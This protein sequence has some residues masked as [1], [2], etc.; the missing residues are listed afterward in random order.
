MKTLVLPLLLILGL[1][2][3]LAG[4]PRVRDAELDKLTLDEL[5][6]IE[7]QTATRRPEVPTRSPVAVTVLTRDDIR[8]SGAQTLVELL[9]LVPGVHVAQIDGNKWAVGI[10]GFADRLSRG[11]LVMIDGRTVYTP[12][13]AGTY[14]EM[15]HTLLEDID[16]IEVIRGPGGTLWGA[17]AVNGIINVI[18][19]SAADTQGGLLTGGGGNVQHGMASGRYGGRISRTAAYRLY[20]TWFNR[21]P[22]AATDGSSIDGWSMAQGGFRADWT[23]ARTRVLT[24]QGDVYRGDAGQRLVATTY[25]PPFS[26]RLDDDVALTGANL[27]VRWAAGARTGSN[28]VVQTY[29]DRTHRTEALFTEDRH[30]F[31]VDLQHGLAPVGRHRL[32]WGAGY[33]L[34]ADAT[35]AVPIRQ[36]EPAD[37]TT[38]LVSAFAQDQI[39][40]RQN[41]LDLVLGSRFEHNAYSGFEWQPSARLVWTPAPLHT[42]VLSATRAVRTPS[43][44]E[45]DYTTGS[46]L[47]AQVP[48]CLRLEP[49]RDF[50]SE[51]LRG[52][53]ASYRVRLAPQMYATVAGFFNHLTDVLS[54]RTAPP[55]AETAVQP[56]RLILP[57]TFGN[58]L[59]GNSHGMEATLDLRPTPWWSWTAAYSGLRVQL[60]RD[61]GGQDVSQEERGE[62]GSPNHQVQIRSSIDLPGAV[63]IDWAFRYVSQ[64]PVFDVPGYATSDLRAGWHLTRQVSLEVVGR[65]LHRPRHLEFPGGATGNVLVRRGV[66]ARVVTRW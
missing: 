48:F 4:Q 15:Q 13:F 9:R 24:V 50:T 52:Y 55:F 29:V 3:V 16:R 1:P 41:A 11:M 8:R 5:L 31:D 19:K 53:E 18:T 23:P 65:N 54:T 39:T 63:E 34:S 17:N 32:L 37:R 40:L 35:D 42:A 21:G 2:P 36:F 47:N 60:T 26:Q 61:A 44:V 56:P 6:E 57:V 46:V 66:F 58:D 49:D 43:R 20:G 30:T 25:A 45:H 22:G 51:T 7:L 28:V 59:H 27:L 33:R 14:W 62:G 64:L 10:R 38:H 12:L